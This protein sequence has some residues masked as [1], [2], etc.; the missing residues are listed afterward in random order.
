MSEATK[1]ILVAGSTGYLGAYVA[2]ELKT[3]GHY[4]RALARSAD[5]LATLKKQPDDIFLA[6]VTEPDSLRGACDGI[7]VV[8][9]SVGITR[10]KD[11]LTFK[12]VDYQGNLN[13][14]NEAKRAGVKKFIYVSVFDGP[15][16]LHLDIVKAHENF[17]AEL[18]KSGLDYCVIRPTGYFSDMGEF[19]EMAQKGRVWLVGSGVNKM[20]P[21]HGA[22]LAN[23][24]ADAVDRE[25]TEINAGGPEVMTYRQMAETAF[26]ALDRPPKISSVPGWLIKAVVAVTRLF[27]HHQGELLAFFTTVMLTD[28]VAPRYGDHNLLEHYRRLAAK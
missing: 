28:G 17:V 5:K 13:L 12:D 20:N 7:D 16:L 26:K 11:G 19:L 23:V 27:N 22:D 8:F 21:I 9:S 18:T 25:D 10:Q 2:E 6:Q 4:V 3:R 24:C 15:K 14:L 1:R